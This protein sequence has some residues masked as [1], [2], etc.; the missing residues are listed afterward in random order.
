[1]ERVEQQGNLTKQQAEE[2]NNHAQ[3][4]L[5]EAKASKLVAQV[6]PSLDGPLA[7]CCIANDCVDVVDSKSVSLPRSVPISPLLLARVCARSFR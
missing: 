2:A 4:A 6:P 1:M 5:R 3:E 7:S